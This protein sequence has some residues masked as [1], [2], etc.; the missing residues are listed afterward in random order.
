M[1]G[2]PSVVARVERAVRSSSFGQS[3]AT[4]APQWWHHF[5]VAGLE[6]QD[7]L[8][9]IRARTPGDDSGIT[10]FDADGWEE[11]VWILHRLWENRDVPEE[12]SWDDVRK[13]EIRTGRA[14]PFVIGPVNFDE[15]TV[16]TGVPLGGRSA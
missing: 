12:I 8:A 2:R 1:E 3:R 6:G 9:W 10:G 15:D 4:T 11:S 16:L 14:E 7:E 5:C 13:H